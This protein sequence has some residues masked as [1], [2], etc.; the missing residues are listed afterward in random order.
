[1]TFFDNNDLLLQKPVVKHR[2]LLQTPIDV[3]LLLELEQIVD[4]EMEEAGPFSSQDPSM[5][6]ESSDPGSSEPAQVEVYY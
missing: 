1:L 3:R 5:A 4:V 2:F 6:V